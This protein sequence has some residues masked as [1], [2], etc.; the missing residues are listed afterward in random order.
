MKLKNKI[1]AIY[2]LITSAILIVVCLI[3]Y[4]L[5]AQHTR[6]AFYQRLNERA[7]IVAAFVLEEDELSHKMFSDIRRKYMQSLLLEREY[8]ID[9]DAP[10][11][12]DTLPFYIDEKFINAVDQ[13][14]YAAFTIGDTAVVGIRYEDN[15][16]DFA[17]I[18]AAKDRSGISKQQNLG[19]TLVMVVLGALVLIFFAGRWYAKE[20]IAPLNSI[21]RQMH[22]IDS[23]SLHQRIS[24]D[25]QRDEIGQL[26]RAFNKLLDRIE[27]GIEAQASFI[28]N[29]SH[30][31]KNPLT[32]ILGEIEVGLRGERSAEAYRQCL[33]QV[34][35]EAERLKNLTLRLLRLAQ[36][37]VA[38][39][40]GFAPLRIDE[41]LVEVVEDLQQIYPQVPLR[42]HF[43]D[44]PAEAQELEVMA[45]MGLLRAAIANVAE[46]AIKFSSGKPVDIYLFNE[47]RQLRVRVCDRGVGIPEEDRE[48]VFAPFYRAGNA[49]D[50]QGFGVGLSLA[51]KA[52]ELHQGRIEALPGSPGATL[53]I[54]L[55][56]P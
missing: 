10:Q 38:G 34:E 49:S 16:G 30:E 48:K 7:G 21:I 19:R 24:A 31:L 17:V 18:V 39:K 40:E 32:A 5:S 45:D 22:A 12:P 54:V 52:V 37:G 15:Q 1:A 27:T 43:E 55:P 28:S 6:S 35:K 51:R 50:F 4:Y 20:T 36:A 44:M 26:A 29:A 56:K 41:L 46:N 11:R 2:T 3:I 23:S 13:R 14:R 42:L 25:G 53:Q 47:P 33:Q 8:L 9:L